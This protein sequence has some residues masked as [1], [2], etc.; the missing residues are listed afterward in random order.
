MKE[1]NEWIV[2]QKSISYYFNARSFKNFELK[3][4][5]VAKNPLGTNFFTL[6]LRRNPIWKVFMPNN[7]CLSRRSP[8]RVQRPKSF[9]IDP[10]IIIISKHSYAFA[11]YFDNTHCC[12][13]SNSIID[14]FLKKMYANPNNILSKIALQIQD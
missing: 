8:G 10:A 7:A 3:N 9:N 1:L 11:H 2:P 13:S 4:W 6:W 12:H 5:K 14:L